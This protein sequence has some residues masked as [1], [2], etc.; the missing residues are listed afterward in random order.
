[1]FTAKNAYLEVKY[2]EARYNTKFIRCGVTIT[3]CFGLLGGHHQ[4]YYVSYRRLPIM[5]ELRG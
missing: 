1:M 4:V 5:R 2:N 3:T